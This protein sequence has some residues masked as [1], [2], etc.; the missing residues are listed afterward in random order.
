MTFYKPRKTIYGKGEIFKEGKFLCNVSYKYVRIGDRTGEQIQINGELLI[1]ESKRKS[2]EILNV[3]LES[4]VELHA[5]NGAKMDIRVYKANE[6]SL[7][8]EYAWQLWVDG[9]FPIK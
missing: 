3:I 5:E 4:L 1:E 9:N 8:G 2:L 6:K 7:D